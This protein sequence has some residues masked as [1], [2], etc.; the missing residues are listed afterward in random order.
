MVVHVLSYDA[1]SYS[2]CGVAIGRVFHVGEVIVMTQTKRNVLVF[3]FLGWVVRLTLKKM[4]GK[5]EWKYLD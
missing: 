4:E 1:E 2:G 5:K 3:Q